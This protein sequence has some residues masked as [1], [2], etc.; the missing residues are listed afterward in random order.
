[1]NDRIQDAL[2]FHAHELGRDS[3]A[4]AERRWLKWVA[5]VEALTGLATLDG[6]GQE[7]GYSLDEAY[8]WYRARWSAQRAASEINAVLDANFAAGEDR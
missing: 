7:D 8:D 2:D 4:A 5:E 6:D 3:E 1:M